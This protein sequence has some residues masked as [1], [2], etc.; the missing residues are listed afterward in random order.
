MHFLGLAGMPRRIPDYPDAYALWNSVA[1]YGAWI[2]FLSALYFIYVL[3]R[4]FG[5]APGRLQWENFQVFYPHQR[6]MHS[7][8]FLKGERLP[9]EEF[10]VLLLLKPARKLAPAETRPKTLLDSLMICFFGHLAG[11]NYPR[12]PENW[13]VGQKERGAAGRRSLPLALLYGGALADAPRPAQLGF[14]DSATEGFFSMGNLHHSIWVWLNLVLVLVFG[15]L[16]MII[17]VF[18]LKRLIY[19][20]LKVK[21]RLNITEDTPLEF[22]WTLV[23]MV[24]LVFIAVPSLSLLYA[25]E[26]FSGA[27]ALV[28]QVVGRQWYWVYEYPSFAANLLE[29]DS[30]ETEAELRDPLDQRYPNMGLRLLD[31]TPLLLP[32]ALEL[33]FLTASEDV[34]HGFALPSAGLKMDAVPGRLNQALST[35]LRPGIFYGQ[36]SELCGS[37]HGFMPITAQV[38]VESLF[39]MGLLEKAELMGDYLDQWR[40]I[41]ALR[42]ET[43]RLPSM[44]DYIGLLAMGI[45][46][47]DPLFY[48]GSP[49]LPHAT[50]ILEPE[51]VAQLME[52]RAT[53]VE[54]MRALVENARS[55]PYVEE[56]PQGTPEE[57]AKDAALLAQIAADM[58]EAARAKYSLIP[59]RRPGTGPGTGGPSSSALLFLLLDLQRSSQTAAARPNH[60][61]PL[62]PETANPTST[63]TRHGS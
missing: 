12:Y 48:S 39:H 55:K 38:V 33:E 58:E 22:A 16:A 52:E 9:W 43:T 49:Y 7:Y 40:G 20:L 41:H 35:F 19:S 36:C 14:Q 42:S 30:L 11:A 21:E 37:G 24:I 46:P 53:R 1:S 57:I 56:A 17:Y 50:K 51:E 2:S 47:D 26:E 62:T 28:I 63:S 25:L 8:R 5:S 18:W 32:L 61:T 15:L 6:V 4:I 29:V 27:A 23:P 31:S 59:R 10:L 34:I 54:S 44:R 3:V 60:L 13:G 45:T